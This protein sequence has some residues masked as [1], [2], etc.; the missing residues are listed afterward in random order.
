[1]SLFTID[2]DKCTGDGICA[3]VCPVGI[4]KAP[5]KGSYPE[6]VPGAERICIECGHCLAVCP[7][8]ALALES[9]KEKEIPGFDPGLLPS[10]EQLELAMRARR[11]VRLYQDKPVPRDLLAKLIAVARY[12]PSGHN[13]QPVHWL[14]IEN[15][16]EVQRL[17]GL[18]IDWMRLMDKENPAQAGTIGLGKLV[19][20]WDKG[21][22][23]ICRS[24]PH[25]VIAHAA[26]TMGLSACAIALTYLELAAFANGLGACWAGFLHWAATS[27]PP[28]QQA[29]ALPEGHQCC[30]ALMIG[31]PKFRYHRIPARK[32]PPVTWR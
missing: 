26:S 9:M 10:P 17:A 12:A 8:G 6:P 4:I 5:E 18:V 22:D 7:Q 29:L 31:Y 20:G 13:S 14:V 24:A 23:L 21:K 1:M 25:L 3:A 15:P 2:R 11:S 30:G 27:Y 16:D 19:E 32:E 28:L